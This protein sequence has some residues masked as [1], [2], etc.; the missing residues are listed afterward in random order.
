MTCPY[1]IIQGA[2]PFQNEPPSLRAEL[3]RFKTSPLTNPAGL[4]SAR[5]SR[6]A[7]AVS[8]WSTLSLPAV[9]S[10]NAVPA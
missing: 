4:F 7:R 10:E 5:G 6:G 1:D 3:C 2:I 9:V 8:M